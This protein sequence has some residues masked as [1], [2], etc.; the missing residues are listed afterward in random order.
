[1]S[2]IAHNRRTS[3]MNVPKGIEKPLEKYRT[4]IKQHFLK[5]DKGDENDPKILQGLFLSFPR[6]KARKKACERE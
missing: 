3:F 5:I 4:R 6:L 1:M 2:N